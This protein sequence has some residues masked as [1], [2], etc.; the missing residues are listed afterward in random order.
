[1]YGQVLLKDFF[2]VINILLI[3]YLFKDKKGTKKSRKKQSW[4][5]YFLCL[6]S[7]FFIRLIENGLPLHIV[8][9]YLT[10]LMIVMIIGHFLFQC[11][12]KYSILIGSIFL[13]IVLFGE[14]LSCILFYPYSANT[15]LAEIDSKGKIVMILITE[16]VIITGSLL[17]KRA[18]GK[19]PSYLRR[20]SVFIIMMPLSL[21]IVIMAICADQLYYEED[22]IMKNIYSSITILIACVIM[23]I[24]T[25]CNIVILE[26]YLKVKKIENETNL[27]ISEISLQ[28]D[29][30]MKQVKDM[31]N[32]RRLSHD[33]KNHL[34][35]L[36]GDIDNE[37]KM[38]YINGIERKLSKYQSYYKTGNAFI[39]SL[40]H[41]KRLEAIE[42]GIE[43]KVLV[44]FTPFKKIKD[45]D[46]C[47]I[48]SNIIDNALYECHLIRE[49]S[50]DSGC[51]I[52]LKARKVKSFLSILCENSIR[53][54]QEELLRKRVVWDT[55]KEDKR[56][57]GIGIKN[58]K[59]VVQEYGGE[60]SFHIENGMFSVSI[61]IPINL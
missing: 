15:I 13:S 33:I 14:L 43:F 16:S 46:L 10:I 48:I 41:V 9:N 27:Q 7:L 51:L 22:M 4:Y 52:Q 11:D 50:P 30:Y 56:N 53:K 23:F 61:I 34:E 40:L 45:E 38:E 25:I 5:S 3:T 20:I 54:S 19:I 60:V 42:G 49:E 29:Y 24:G 17:L 31:E 59:R 8:Y 35:A 37:R 39:D 12:V 32:I 18:I 58:V 36:K 47:V 26:N 1:M 57:H 28:Y 44:D 6:G 2:S 55:T 21:N